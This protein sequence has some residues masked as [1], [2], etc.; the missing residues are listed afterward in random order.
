[1]VQGSRASWLWP[2]SSR[3]AL[4]DIPSPFTK[5]LSAMVARSAWPVVVAQG[6][7]DGVHRGVFHGPTQH[8]QFLSQRGMHRD[9]LGW[10]LCELGAGQAIRPQTAV[11]FLLSRH[12]LEVT[13]NDA[14]RNARRTPIAT[15]AME[16]V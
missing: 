5:G 3:R 9:G 11:G 10:A 13:M 6:V 7:G 4:G 8:T 15:E 14:K 1:M 16:L 12:Q 2:S